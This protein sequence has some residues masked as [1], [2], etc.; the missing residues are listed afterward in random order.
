MGRTKVYPISATVLAVLGAFC[1]VYCLAILIFG[2]YGSLFF[3]VWGILGLLC[4][5]L[6]VVHS[7]RILL[8]K[9]PKWFR[10]MVWGLC[11]AGLLLFCV[12][13]G[14]VCSQFAATPNPGADYCIILGA[15]WKSTGP[16][17][18][19]RKRLDAAIEYLNENPETLV[20]V[21]GG[22]GSN[23]VMSEAAGMQD[24]LINAGIDASR[25][26][27]EDK[28]TNTYEN[29]TYSADFLDE[30]NDRVVIVTNNFHTFRALSIAKKQ[31]YV[32]A[33][34]LS[35]DS[36]LWFLPNN[37]L[38]EFVGIMKDFAFGNL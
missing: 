8:N 32:N 37:M 17:T 33:E 5:I 24:Y 11:G 31:G 38:R 4:L 14:M 16:S 18:V 3:L 29:L 15:Q 9:I 26:I 6:A 22:Q 20:I 27:M 35:A 34:G 21:S 10:I 7:S 12:V 19:L 13:E 36:V 30:Q 23:E 28:S 2:G 1:I 25:I